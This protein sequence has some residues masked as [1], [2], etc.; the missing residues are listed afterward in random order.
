MVTTRMETTRHELG[1]PADTHDAFRA[2][3]PLFGSHLCPV[4]DR[5]GPLTG[6]DE[7]PDPI[8][9]EA[10][11]FVWCVVLMAAMIGLSAVAGWL[12]PLE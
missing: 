10:R 1:Q 8:P 6:D 5:R 7:S 3:S 12:L 9:F 2:S 4:A 11:V